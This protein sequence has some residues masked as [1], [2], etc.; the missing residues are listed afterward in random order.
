MEWQIIIYRRR[1]CSCGFFLF[2]FVNDG[3]FFV[4]MQDVEYYCNDVYWNQDDCQQDDLMLDV[5]IIYVLY[6]YEVMFGW[7]YFEVCVFKV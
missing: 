6:F 2:V 3:L 1:G 4:V 5:E 7:Q